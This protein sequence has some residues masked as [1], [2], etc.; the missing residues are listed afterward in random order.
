MTEAWTFFFW[1]LIGAFIISV[2]VCEKKEI[3]AVFLSSFIALFWELLVEPF[4]WYFKLWPVAPHLDDPIE[5]FY[6]SLQ[7]GFEFYAAYYALGMLYILI[8]KSQ[9]TYKIQVL[10]GFC[11]GLSVVGW[12]G[13][14]FIAR[15]DTYVITFFVW[16]TL[17]ILHL[18]GVIKLY[19]YFYKIQI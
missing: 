11:L 18:I 16:L 19:N 8:Y 2:F 10:I 9:H 1:G 4:G 12:L 5:V 14:I 7:L 3:V 15:F 13:D 6:I 17:N